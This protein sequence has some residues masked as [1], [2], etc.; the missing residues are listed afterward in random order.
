MGWLLLEMLV[1]LLLAVA[2][3]GWTMGFGTKKRPPPTDRDSR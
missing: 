3:V 2:I 1:A